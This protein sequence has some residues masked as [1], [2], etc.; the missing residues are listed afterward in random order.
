MISQIS[1]NADGGRQRSEEMQAHKFRAMFRERVAQR[2]DQ[3]IILAA[4]ICSVLG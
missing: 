1:S 4:S 2:V 3:S